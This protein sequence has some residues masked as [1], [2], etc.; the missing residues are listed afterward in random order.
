MIVSKTAS[1]P[2]F[3]KAQSVNVCIQIAHLLASLCKPDEADRVLVP[4]ILCTF[5]LSESKSS[6]LFFLS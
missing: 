6:S 1:K 5:V 3:E 4:S 2:P